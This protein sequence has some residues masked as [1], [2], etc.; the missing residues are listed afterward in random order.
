[1]R[2]GDTIADRYEILRS[3]RAGA[4][5]MVFE[6]VD[7]RTARRVAVKVIAVPREDNGIERR[8]ARESKILAALSHPSI[9]AYHSSGKLA[10]GRIYVVLEW[11]VGQDLADYKD[12]H[13]LPLGFVLGL[14]AQVA[15]GLAAA[16]EKGIIHRD[17]KPANIFLVEP[18]PS[19]A[20]DAR[21]IDFGVAKAEEGAG[22]GLTRAG[23][24]LGTPAYMA[25]EQANHAMHVDGRADVFSLG[26]VLYE[27]ISGEL[28]WASRSDLA[29]LA[30]ITVE[31]PIPLEEKKPGLP[32]PVS[33]LVNRMLALDPAER[34]GG[35]AEVESQLL[36]LE[37]GL[38]GAERSLSHRGAAPDLKRF[39]S[40]PTSARVEVALPPE[41]PEVQE[42]ATEI[43]RQKLERGKSAPTPIVLNAVEEDAALV[44]DPASSAQARK[45]V[46]L[47]G[48][49]AL[50]D[51]LV[52]ETRRALESERTTRLA[53]IGPA[54]IGKTRLRIELGR[55]LKKKLRG[56]H[57][58]TARADDAM[59]STPYGFLR[60]LLL[61]EARISS[62]DS[63]RTMLEKLRALLPPN[64]EISQR[65]RQRTS[66]H[67]GGDGKS[68]ER[69]RF[70]RVERWTER[71][72]IVAAMTDAF[73]LD[74]ASTLPTD[75][76]GDQEMVLSFLAEALGVP[77]PARAE[78]VAAKKDPRVMG[79]ETRRSLDLA[80][81]GLAE[82]RGL[83]L[84]VDD[85][86][87]LDRQS[88]AVLAELSETSEGLA[89]FTVVFA[90]PSLLDA[91]AEGRGPWNLKDTVV[92]DL[93]PLDAAS[94]RMLARAV[95]SQPVRADAVEVLA[96]RAEGN[97]L[98]LE[99]LVRAVIETAVLA[100][101]KG[102][103]LSLVGLRGDSEDAERIP[104]SIT[105]AVRAR[106][107]VMDPNLLEVL[108][109]AVVFGDVFWAEGVA[110]VTGRDLE[111][112][113]F[114]IDRLVLADFVRHR[115]SSRYPGLT[116]VEL[117]HQVVRTVV[118]ARLKQKERRELERKV[119]E[120]LRRAVETDAATL[121]AH[122]VRAGMREEAAELYRRAAERSI[123]AGDFAAASLLA[124][125][126]LL[127]VESVEPQTQIGLYEIAARA[128]SLAQD[129][130]RAAE[131]LDALLGLPLSD[132][133][134]AEVSL[135]RA[136]VAFAERDLTGAVRFGSDAAHAFASA[137]LGEKERAAELVIAEANEAE[138]DERAA[139]KAYVR[140]QGAFD[141]DQ[142]R[143][144]LARATAGL[145]RIAL[146]SGDYRTAESRFRTALAHARA[147]F[148]VD[149][150]V[151]ALLGLGTIAQRKG[152]H[153]RGLAFFEAA[154]RLVPDAPRAGELWA[155]RALLLAE[156]GALDR[157]ESQIEVAL[158]ELWKGGLG[159][160]AIVPT[161][162]WAEIAVGFS[163]PLGRPTAELLA[164][165]LAIMGELAETRAPALKVPFDAYLGHALVVMGDGPRG[166]ER[167]EEAMRRFTVTGTLREEEAP[168]IF[169]LHATTLKRLSAPAA[170]IKEALGRG[171]EQLDL[172]LSRLE[173]QDREQVLERPQSRQLLGAA[174]A[175][176]V[177][178]EQ[179][180][181]SHRLVMGGHSD[182]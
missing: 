16:H 1:M 126:G 44:P 39:L 105:A 88:A 145:A 29:R 163:G 34:P 69:T 27:L 11:L 172:L 180:P 114:R 177:D 151:E 92:L 176:G 66:A 84:L 161:L 59:R 36:A 130:A 45:E 167:S 171:V 76:D 75:E 150:L 18:D 57:V 53:V 10:E 28:P 37:R 24:I 137:G 153:Q 122:Q 140:L 80:L 127:L 109:A 134:R 124:D 152:S 182:R 101:M 52:E 142:D 104:P 91:E 15:S 26:V 19:K 136:E 138:T 23:A 74:S 179:D 135:V 33:A 2:P 169:W 73:E 119:V 48:R 8:M 14:G 38:S 89:L 56:A 96:Q 47:I 22:D 110:E 6:A 158:T 139:L 87:L 125:E 46:P 50:L 116:E 154:E 164:D 72:S 144:A 58:L 99:H 106:L 98:Y 17:I 35:M 32:A 166:R 95:A 54:G 146:G 128:R 129:H 143:A 147:A 60:R 102:G 51:R 20:P 68:E 141:R 25:P 64:E 63:S 115:S 40:E 7:K 117:S 77:G 70:A 61:S 162:L 82:R 111:E 21:V 43:S 112:T 155:R 81:R 157:A 103:E 159:H 3:A 121:A 62:S 31:E 178:F 85:A 65:I 120:F 181:R 174:E 149:G 78:L 173:R 107:A 83:V 133:K 49:R 42:P 90:L 132:D 4:S 168:R 30:R 71:P 79:V 67:A 123:D 9:V 160:A 170:E 148:S 5:G 113:L 13:A 94:S 100:P 55:T 118:A 156:M 93:P 86:H 97:P 108:T 41:S 12:K 175:A 165:R 131:A